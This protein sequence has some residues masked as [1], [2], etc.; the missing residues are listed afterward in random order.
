MCDLCTINAKKVKLLDY[1]CANNI[2]KAV[3]NNINITSIPRYQANNWGQLQPGVDNTTYVC[4]DVKQKIMHNNVTLLNHTTTSYDYSVLG[5]YRTSI[6]T[7]VVCKKNV[8]FVP[9]EKL[10]AKERSRR[11]R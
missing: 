5:A 6:K 8:K 2:N 4:L 10:E 7:N 3:N 11:I 1:L 9:L